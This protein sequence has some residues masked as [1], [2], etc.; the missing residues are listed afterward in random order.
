MDCWA[1][2]KSDE[3][4]YRACVRKPDVYL[5]RLEGREMLWK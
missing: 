1:A 3:E 4:M 2:R 5:V